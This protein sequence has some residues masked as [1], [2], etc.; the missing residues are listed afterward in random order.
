MRTVVFGRYADVWV[1]GLCG[2]IEYLTSLQVTK[3]HYTDTHKHIRICKYTNLVE[4]KGIR[5]VGLNCSEIRKEFIR[6]LS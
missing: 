5:R 4:R 1:C 3:A 2:K 6:D